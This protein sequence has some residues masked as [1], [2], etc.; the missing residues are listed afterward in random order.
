MIDAAAGISGIAR[1]SRKR[2]KPFRPADGK[3]RRK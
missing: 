1:E 3:I 2:E